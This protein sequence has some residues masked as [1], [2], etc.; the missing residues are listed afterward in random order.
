MRAASAPFNRCAFRRCGLLVVGGQQAQQ[1][2][3]NAAVF[4]DQLAKAHRQLESPRPGAAGIEIEHSVARLVLGN[5]TVAAYDNRES[6]GFGLE[7][8]LRQ[9]VQHVDGNTAQFERL[10][11]RQL[12]RPRTFVYIATHGSDGGNG[13]EIVENLRRPN[14]SGMN[15]VVGPAQS[16]N[17]LVTQQAVGVRD[18][19]D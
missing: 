17:G 1:F 4:D 5:V 7:I 3:T 16:C 9:I 15:D 19:A 8:Q 10:G 2:A 12:A 14:I 6:G 18:D 11:F 13:R